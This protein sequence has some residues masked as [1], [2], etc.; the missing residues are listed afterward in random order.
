MC[1]GVVEWGVGFLNEYI[2]ALMSLD[3]VKEL[4]TLPLGQQLYSISQFVYIVKFIGRGTTPPLAM[5]E[6][7][8]HR[9]CFLRQWVP[10]TLLPLFPRTVGTSSPSLFVC[11]DSGYLTPFSLWFLRL[12][13]PHTFSLCFLRQWVSHPLCFL[14]QWV[15]HPI[16]PLVP[17]TVGTS[18]PLFPETVGTSPHSPFGS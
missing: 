6:P 17:E 18:S 13:V 9:L 14:R 8:L 3:R 11:S 2:R 4:S 16:L 5:N 12:W 10:D 7:F 15:P 1:V